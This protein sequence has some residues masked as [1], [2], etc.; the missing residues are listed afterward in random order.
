MAIQSVNPFTNQV[1]KTFQALNAEAID[2]RIQ[3]AANAYKQWRKTSFAERKKLMLQAAALLR[4][5]A[6]HYARLMTLE[7]GKL[8]KEGIEWELPNCADM[9]EYYANNAERF[10]AAEPITEVSE[11]EAYLES[12][13]LGVIFGVMP[14]NFP[15]YQVIRFIAPNI[16]A[17]NTV[18]FKHASNVPQCAQAIEA[19]FREAGFP[20]GVVSNLLINASDAQRVIAHPAVCAV[21]LTGSERA[22]ASV[23]SQAG[24][25]LKKAVMELGGSDAFI[26]TADVDIAEIGEIAY[27]AKMFN[28]GQVCTGAKR[29]I[30]LKEKYDEFLADFTQRMAAARPGD[31]L[32]SETDY[33]PMVSVEEAD[34]LAQVIQ[35]A[36]AQ[37]ATIHLGGTRPDQPGAWLPPTI[38]TNVTKDMDIYRL[39][40]FG[41]AAMVFKVDTLDEAIEL[42][43]DSEY[44]LSSAIMCRDLTLAR[45]LA[46]RLETGVTFINAM[47]ISEPCLPL[48]GVKKSGFGRELGRQG[49]EEFINKKLV[50]LL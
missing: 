4:Q 8:L 1:E 12:H 2:A 33:G 48:G 35:Q 28:S 25:Q 18:I 41:P 27:T 6:E 26:I 24:Q 37:G 14:W 21:S 5:N 36:K 3:Q 7:M 31:P 39:E 16:M 46:S 20:E 15:F 45:Q 19:V 50:R 10:M 49:M 29:Y 38:I 40:L 13:P 43:N 47:T 23:A 22:G 42:A 32:H 11:G 30:V 9:C 34:K 17:G 44:G